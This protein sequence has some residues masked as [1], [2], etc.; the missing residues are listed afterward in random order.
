MK[1]ADFSLGLSS[2]NFAVCWY[3]HVYQIVTGRLMGHC[4]FA[5]WRLLF[6]VVCRRLPTGRRAGRRARGRSAAAGPGAWVVGRPTLHGGP[7]RVRPIRATHCF[8]RDASPCLKW[9]FDGPRSRRVELWGSLQRKMNYYFE[10]MCFTAVW[11][12]NLLS[13]TIELLQ[14]T[15]NH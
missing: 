14:Q 11:M 4:C 2:H 12:A 15:L 10:L 5:R 13:F 6:V 9:R 3:I 8:R 7:V 1:F